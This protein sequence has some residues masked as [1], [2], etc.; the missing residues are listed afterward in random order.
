MIS[1]IIVRRLLQKKNFIFVCNKPAGFLHPS[2]TLHRA[3][4][5][6]EFIGSPT[7]LRGFHPSRLLHTLSYEQWQWSRSSRSFGAK[8]GYHTS[9]FWGAM[10]RTSYLD[11]IMGPNPTNR[12]RP[13]R[14]KPDPI[15][16]MQRTGTGYNFWPAIIHGPGT[17]H[18]F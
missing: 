3:L 2:P 16:P 6:F 5:Q 1:T 15:Q 7:N 17:S 13:V 14:K 8:R 11:L 4:R 9:R 10:T 12:T 18:D